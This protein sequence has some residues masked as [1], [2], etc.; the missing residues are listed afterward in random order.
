[1]VVK[2]TV[3]KDKGLASQS[4]EPGEPCLELKEGISTSG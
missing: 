1:M 2:G 4:S 3:S